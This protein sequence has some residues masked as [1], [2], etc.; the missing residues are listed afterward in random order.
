M[1]ISKERIF[2]YF[3][4]KL[5]EKMKHFSTQELLQKMKDNTYY[6]PYNIWHKLFDK[7]SFYGGK[8]ISWFA[9]RQV[10]HIKNFEDF[11]FLR[12]NIENRNF[13]KELVHNSYF[14]LGHLAKNI[15]SKEIFDYL[16]AKLKIESN[17]NKVTILI[18]L[19]DCEK[20]TDFDLS[21]IYDII[22]NGENELRPKAVMC[23]NKSRN[24]KSESILLNLI[25][26]ESNKHVRNMAV[27]T[28]EDIGT[29]KS[30]EIIK[31]ELKN[32]RS[33]DYRYY[34][35]RAIIEIEERENCR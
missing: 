25:P 8:Q 32:T 33:N 14:A 23:L 30:L 1:G 16:M 26:F 22:E 13:D 24:S 3:E 31:R 6:F 19:Y 27:A 5:I 35:N 18:A 12:Y 21:S 4:K 10:E 2:E 11:H 29:Q 20:P 34:L 17:E 7:G 15:N 28:I 9:T